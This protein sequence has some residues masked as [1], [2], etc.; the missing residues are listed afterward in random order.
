[1]QHHPRLV[2]LIVACALF[3]E[4]LDSTVIATSLPAIAADIGANP[5]ALKLAVTSYLLSLAVF[6]PASGWTA[7]RFGARRVFAAAIFVFM[8]GSIGCAWASSLEGFVAA[9]IVQGMGGA[10][11]TPVG[12][13]VLVRTIEKR[14]LVSAMAWVTI[15]ALIGPVVG[16]PVGGFITTYASWHWIFLINIPIGMV[17]IILVLLYID[18]VPAEHQEPFDGTGMLLAG[19][20]VAGL[21]F[22]LSV[23]GL[24][25]L[26]W[27]VI[28]ALVAGGAIAMT[29]YLVHAKKV[30]APILDFSLLRYA[31]FRASVV[32]GFLFRL[33]IG[34]LPFLL[35]LMLQTGFGM[36]PFQS[37]LVTFAGAIGAIGMKTVAARTISHF[38][39]KRVLVAN[40]LISAALIAAIAIFRP[41]MPVSVLI[42]IL[43][44][45]GFFR[46][47]EFTAVNTIAYAEVDQRRM[48]RATALVSVGQQLSIS[49]GV[50]VGALMVEMSLRYRGAAEFTAADFT[51][52]FLV[53]AA[54]SA[55]SVFWFYRLPSDAGAEMSGR[56]AIETEPVK[57]AE[58]IAAAETS[59]R[60]L[61]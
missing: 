47:L 36:T 54:I 53:V 8:L 13:L 6:I 46:A 41:G 43:L 61:G 20:G 30:P 18:P 7:D 23:A 58:P 1:M 33:G 17:G 15:P 49:A 50:A 19:L 32:G 51:P 21:A 42:A 9:R 40:A 37:G 12:R 22:G 45:G 11:M 16:P 38:G 60:R 29:A 25:I 55:A 28:V 5:L 3:M 27:P 31:T 57:D 59:D 4:N 48:S 56:T 24:D 26:P 34:A 44:V 52:A 39:F 2:P 14:D 10:M 35:P